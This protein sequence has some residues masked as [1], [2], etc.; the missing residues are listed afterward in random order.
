HQSDLESAQSQVAGDAGA[1]DATPDDQHVERAALERLEIPVADVP[2]RHARGLKGCGS[3]SAGVNWP[4]PSTK[5]RAS[6]AKCSAMTC[7]HA[8]QGEQPPSGASGQ[9]TARAV[10]GRVAPDATAAKTALR[11]AQTV[12]P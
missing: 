7:R 9:V 1:D 12:R 11:S 8:P 6:G 3:S 5:I 10:K 2:D 4:V